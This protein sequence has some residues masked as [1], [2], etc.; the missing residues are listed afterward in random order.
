MK[1]I[2]A[3]IRPH[4]QPY[5]LAALAQMGISNVTVIETLGLGRQPSYSQ[6]YEPSSPHKETQTGLV[7]KRLLLLFVEDDQL[8]PVVDVIQS[9]GFTGAPG[10]GKIAVSQLEQVVRI[11]PKGSPVQ[12]K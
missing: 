10:D 3:V 11:R 5:V 2:E 1:R 4:K 9:Q 8:Q 12:S 6:I 7:P